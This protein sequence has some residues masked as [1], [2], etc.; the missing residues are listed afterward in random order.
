MVAASVVNAPAIL[1]A[2]VGFMTSMT[3]SSGSVFASSAKTSRAYVVEALRVDQSASMAR[4]DL[5]NDIYIQRQVLAG[6][7]IASTQ[8]AGV[9]ALNFRNT[10]IKP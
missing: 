6:L 5:A 3:G 1:I 7:E 8:L 4:A 10:D 9:P 2:G